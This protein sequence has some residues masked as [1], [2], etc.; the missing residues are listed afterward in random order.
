VT[1]QAAPL[2]RIPSAEEIATHPAYM[3]GTWTDARTGMGLIEFLTFHLGAGEATALLAEAD[4]IRSAHLPAR[5]P[6]KMPP[7]PP[8]HGLVWADPN[9]V[10]H[11]PIPMRQVTVCGTLLPPSPTFLPAG[12]IACPTCFEVPS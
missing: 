5:P 2:T 1:A 9:G 10:D 8:G 7:P 12:G 11:D 6:V 4:N 3:C